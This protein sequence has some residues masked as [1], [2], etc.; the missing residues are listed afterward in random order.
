[1]ALGRSGTH[2]TLPCAG[3]RYREMACGVGLDGSDSRRTYAP[4]RPFRTSIA[5]SRKAG[6]NRPVDEGQSRC[7][8]RAC[9]RLAAH[10]RPR[11]RSVSIGKRRQY[12]GRSRE[13]ADHRR[14]EVIDFDLEHLA[15]E[16]PPTRPNHPFSVLT[17]TPYRALH[18]LS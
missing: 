10:R 4:V 8:G 12:I 16:C 18:T 5:G 9:L 17:R 13:F 1:M 11:N 15:F 14:W 6:T 2:V 7:H 3:A